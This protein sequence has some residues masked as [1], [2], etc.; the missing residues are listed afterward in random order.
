MH[1]LHL[2]PGIGSVHAL[3]TM[4]ISLRGFVKP[5]CGALR[6]PKPDL[7]VRSPPGWTPDP[8]SSLLEESPHKHLAR[9]RV[10]RVCRC[11]RHRDL[12]G[13]RRRDESRA[14]VRGLRE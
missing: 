6:S 2:P 4:E 5:L 8:V 13:G 14:R 11:V 7:G 12:G 1:R 10:P 3:L 9:D